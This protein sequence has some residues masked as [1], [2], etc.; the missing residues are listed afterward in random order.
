MTEQ[1]SWSRPRLTCIPLRE[2]ELYLELCLPLHAMAHELEGHS[3]TLIA[4]INM[5]L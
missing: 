3:R 5:R 2:S 4:P 1:G